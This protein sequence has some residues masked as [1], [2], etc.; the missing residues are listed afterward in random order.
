MKLFH[1]L[2]YMQRND[3]VVTLLLLLVAV[4]AL[5]IVTFVGRVFDST[6]P[7]GRQLCGVGRARTYSL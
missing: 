1:H 4:A 6:P 5:L 3:R 7:S 2:T